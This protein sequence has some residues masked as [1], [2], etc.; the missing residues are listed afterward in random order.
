M[1]QLANRLPQHDFDVAAV[2]ADFPNLARLVRGKPLIYFDNAASAQRPRAMLDATSAYYTHCNANVH[3]GVHSLS[4]EATD[5]FEHAREQMRCF[6]GAADLGEVIFVRGA[7]EAVN[8][9]SQAY[10]RPRIKPGEQILISHMEHHSNIVP[11]QLLCEQTGA[12]LKVIPINSEGEILQDAFEQMLNP[13]VK[14]LAVVHV[15]NAL[16]TINPIKRMV[17]AAHAH[18]IPVLVD[19][20]QGAPHLALDMVDLDCDFYCVS[21]HKMF[22][23]TGIGVLFGKREILESMPPYHGGGE[24]IRQVSFGGTTFNDL[25]FK[26]EAGTPNIAG[27]IGLGASALYLSGLGLDRLRQYE[28]ELLAYATAAIEQIKGLRIIG[29]ARDKAAVISFAVENVHPNDLGTILDHQG[30]AIR[31]GHHCTM[32]LMEF[33]GLPGTARASLAFYNTREEVDDF[34]VALQRAIKMLA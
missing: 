12:E 6:I 5:A 9:V 20:A 23:P 29:T 34:I 8:L 7:T 26:Y 10:L 13:Q 16:G 3:R 11:W 32:P 19:G 22:G 2:R 18:G 1:S 17:A 4:Q 30:V 15:S 25:P 33:F 24:M 21:G 27:A 31:T 28:S 14:M